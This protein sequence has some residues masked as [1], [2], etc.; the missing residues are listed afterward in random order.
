MNILKP[1]TFEE[2]CDI[3]RAIAREQH[4]K[5]NIHDYPEY[6][7]ASIVFMTDKFGGCYL[8]LHWEHPT[9]KLILWRHCKKRAREVTSVSQLK[10][11]VSYYRRKEEKVRFADNSLSDFINSQY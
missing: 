7:W 6:N 1:A 2:V 3:C 5:I 9:Q 11:L 4:T 10:T 8:D